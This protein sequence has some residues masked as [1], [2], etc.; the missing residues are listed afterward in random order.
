MNKIF[1]FAAAVALASCDLDINED[2]NYPSS[3]NVTPDLVFP[4]AQNAVA[5][6]VGDELFNCSGFFA[7][8]FDQRPETNQYNDLAELNLDESSDE[9]NRAYSAIYAG[10]LADLKDITDRDDN[11]SDQFACTVMRAQA[12]TLMVDCFSDAPYT[13]ALM[14]SANPNPKWDEGKTIYEGLLAEMDAAEARLDGTP[15]TLKDIIC[16]GSTAA[17]QGYANALRLKMLLRLIDA[18]IDAQ[19]NTQKVQALLAKAQWPDGDVS[20]DVYTNSEGQWNPWYAAKRSLGANNH[21]PAYPIVSYYQ[22]TNDPR[23]AYAIKVNAKEGKYVGQLPGCKTLYQQWTGAK[24]LNKEVSEIDYEVMADAAICLLPASEVQFLIAE[25]QLRF[26]HDNGAA[27]AAYEAGVRADFGYRGIAGADA[28]LA[29]A[30]TAFDSQAD[31][32]AKLNLIYMQKWAALFM[33]N[34]FEAWSEARRTDIPATS[35]TEAKVIY[36]DPS[37]YTAGDFILPGLNYKAAG[38]LIKRLPYPSTA[39][40]YNKN[41]P[42]PKTIAEPVFWDVK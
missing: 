4:A 41:M 11:A 13:E 24:W 32:Q 29:G 42:A 36:N 6:V 19:A 5:D 26:N 38:K 2:P 9:L 3:S 40:R 17:W 1:I 22:A 18:G 37:K 30:K 39:R 27:K 8:Y 35:A 21:V 16:G 31:D 7:Q 12:L 14:G 10:A 20:Y 23:I 15:M 28:L 33:V 34:H 25:A